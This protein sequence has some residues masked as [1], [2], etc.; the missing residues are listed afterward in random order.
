MVLTPR[1]VQMSQSAALISPQKAIRHKEIVA[2]TQLEQ[3]PFASQSTP[4]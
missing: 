2:K 1:S 4:N 3:S